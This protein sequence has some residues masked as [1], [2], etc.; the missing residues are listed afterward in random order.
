MN[1]FLK[2]LSLM[3]LMAIISGCQC[4]PMTARYGDVI[5][6][7]SDSKLELERFYEPG[8]DVSRIGMPDWRRFGWNH[9]LCKCKCR[10]CRT[11]SHPVEYDA[12][13]TLKYHA[14]QAEILGHT[15]GGLQQNITPQAIE[16]MPLPLPEPVPEADKVPLPKM[17]SVPPAS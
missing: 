5:D 10:L 6:D 14:K 11:S 9:K 8:L 3:G 4:T 15:E 12:Y 1:H 16:E 17:K 7:I 2:F 13:Y